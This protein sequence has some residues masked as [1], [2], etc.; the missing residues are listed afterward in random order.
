MSSAPRLPP[1]TPAPA[2]D[3]PVAC[4]NASQLHAGDRVVGGLPQSVAPAAGQDAVELVAG[5]DVRLGEDLVQVVL[6]GG[7]AHEQLGRDPSPARPPPPGEAPCSTGSSLSP[8]AVSVPAGANGVAAH[9]DLVASVPE[10]DTLSDGTTRHVA[11]SLS[12]YGTVAIVH[13]Q[14][15]VVVG[16]LADISSHLT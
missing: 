4:W 5:A 3:R 13:E 16:D 10:A 6:D 9:G 8:S 11:A 15:H 1:G 7:R 12:R 14:R 2:R